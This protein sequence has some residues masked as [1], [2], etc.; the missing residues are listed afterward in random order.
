MAE[1]DELPHGAADP[2]LA[3]DVARWLVEDGHVADCKLNLLSQGQP[4]VVRVLGVIE[5]RPAKIP[6]APGYHAGDAP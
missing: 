5:S 2:L 6:V 1:E 3:V 4:G